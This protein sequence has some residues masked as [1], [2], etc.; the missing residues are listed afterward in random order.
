MKVAIDCRMK[1][2]VATVVR[3]IV[4]HI[5]S[6]VEALY[7]MGDLQRFREWWPDDLGVRTVEFMAPVYGWREQLEYP[8]KRISDCHLLHVP[9]FNI[10][11]RKLPFP[12]LVTINDLAHLAGVLP[13]S[14]AHVQAARL[15][16]RHAVLRAEH[17]TTLSEFARKEI[18]AKL[19]VDPAR[20]SV[21]PCAVDHR[22]FFPADES[23]IREVADRLHICLPY[24]MISGSVRPHKNVGRVLSAFKE[25]KTRNRIPHQL[26]VVGEREG[27]R[28]RTELPTLPDDVQ[29][30]I[31]FTGYIND[32]DMIALYSG[33]EVF[34]YASLYEG[35]GLPPLEAMACGAP[36]AVSRAASLPEV[37][38]DAGVYFDP[39]SVSEIADAMLSLIDNSTK[40]REAVAASLKRAQEFQWERSAQQYLQ[41]YNHVLTARA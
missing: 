13:M 35:F 17:I 40:R 12:L 26:V 18:I 14:W 32:D 28:I 37:I 41:A 10:P 22:K 19:N 23:R 15:Y 36:V 16:Y 38:G 25:L 34:V 4:P 8:L 2:G 9:H 1:H 6:Q 21:I 5:A 33:A 20:I 24:L 7:A 27:F 11:V 31:V 29:S 3:N 39:Y 30:S